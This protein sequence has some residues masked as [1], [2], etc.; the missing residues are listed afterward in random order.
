MSTTLGGDPTVA[1]QWSGLEAFRKGAPENHVPEYDQ[2][3]SRAYCM[4]AQVDGALVWRLLDGTRSLEQIAA[5]ILVAQDLPAGSIDDVREQV[6]D[7]L[8]RL[9]TAGLLVDSGISQ[10]C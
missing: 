6:A 8:E 9:R 1:L 3:D 2:V 7:F 10:A 5:D 4:K